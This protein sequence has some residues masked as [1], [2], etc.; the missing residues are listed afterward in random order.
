MLQKNV[1]I[2][3]PPGYCGSYI[4]W[5][6]HASDTELQKT[7]VKDP[8]NNQNSEKYGGSGT[9]HLHARI[10]THQGFDHHLSWVIYNRPVDSRVYLISTDTGY[11]AIYHAIKIISQ[12]D[13]TGVFVSVHNNNCPAVDAFGTI[14]CVTKWP[15][16]AEIMTLQYPM[17]DT[18]DAYN[19][20]Q[21]RT[22][23]NYVV[24]NN[25]KF[26]R[27]NCIL[28]HD[29]LSKK[30]IDKQEN[31]YKI[32]H[33]AQPHEVNESMYIVNVDLSNRL[34]EISCRDICSD[35]FCTWFD[36]FMKCSQASTAYDQHTVE[37]YHPS[38]IKAQKNLQWFDSLEA[39]KQT[40]Q[41]D[42]YLLS[43]SIIESQLILEIFKQSGLVWL[44]SQQQDQWTSFYAR[45]RGSDW[46][47]ADSE[48]DFFDLPEWVQKE[49]EDFGYDFHIPVKPNKAVLRLDWENA[50]TAD[51]NSAYQQGFH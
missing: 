18:F 32:R 50:T 1:Y 16:F 7:T 23:R 48:Y 24:K 41:L 26:F 17:H 6:I 42:D 51:I 38:Y 27:H 37:T 19:C 40:G 13:P 20:A 15:T 2:L 11:E 5:A 12:A 43:H 8:L 34:F 35:V 3:Y 14:N 47:A 25:Y 10:P 33:R 36:N 49:I 45:C 21:D 44:D 22:F 30:H 4:N 31:W 28:D 29:L 9:S 46:P 39:W